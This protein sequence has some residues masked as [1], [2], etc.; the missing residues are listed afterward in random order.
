VRRTLRLESVIGRE[1]WTL[2]GRRVG[3]LG[4]CRARHDGECWIIEEWV[5]GPAALLERLGVKLRLLVGAGRGSGYVA[6][7]D[8]LDLDDTTRPRLT[9]PLAE[10][11]HMTA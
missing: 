11:R 1:V 2:D 6:R 5:I 3:R 10:L 7:W 4:E 9:C 8:Q